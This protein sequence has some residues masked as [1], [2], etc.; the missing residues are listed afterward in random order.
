M[1]EPP[2]SK[3][4]PVGTR[5]WMRERPASGPF[6]VVGY[7]GTF[8]RIGRRADSTE[9]YECKPEELQSAHVR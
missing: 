2:L 5:C 6:V 9:T 3:V 7:R 8:I 1:A 4:W